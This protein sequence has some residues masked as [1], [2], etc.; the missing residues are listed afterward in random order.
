VVATIFFV[1][2]PFEHLS[3]PIPAHGCDRFSLPPDAPRKGRFLTWD[4]FLGGVAL[5]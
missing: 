5:C 4:H 2:G 1:A 3:K